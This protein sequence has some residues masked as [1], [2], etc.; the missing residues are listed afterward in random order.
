MASFTYTAKREIKAGHTAD[1]SYTIT[2]D[3]ESLSGVMPKP[4][5]NE[6]IALD[7]TTVTVLH[8]SDKV[9]TMSTV[10]LPITGGAYELEDFLEFFASVIG[11]ET[12]VF[13][14][15]ADHNVIM[16]TAPRETRKEGI[17]FSYSLTVRII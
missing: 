15:G 14:D 12:F 13:N 3:L 8:R 10:P 2:V 4:V 16:T 11:G 6:S 7:G 1:T 9:Y 17:Y 5:R